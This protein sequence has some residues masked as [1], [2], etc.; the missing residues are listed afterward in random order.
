MHSNPTSTSCLGNKVR[1]CRTLVAGLLLWPLLQKTDKF[2]SM[3]R[4]GFGLARNNEPTNG[5]FFQA[6]NLNRRRTM[7]TTSLRERAHDLLLGEL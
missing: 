1:R 2:M 5:H 4:K 6:T 3:A 7:N